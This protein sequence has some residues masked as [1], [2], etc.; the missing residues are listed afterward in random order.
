MNVNVD[1]KGSSQ[2][3]KMTETP[4]EKLVLSLALPTIVS[5]L[6]TAVYNMADT[7]FVSHLGT[8]ASAAVGIV[9]SVQSLMQS[10]GFGIGMGAGS[11]VSR[12]LG[13]KEN[14]V[15][16][17]YAM[18]SIVFGFALGIVFLLLAVFDINGLMS[19]FG[20]DADVL[21]YAREYG[22]YILMGAPV[23]CVSFVLNNILRSE[24][25]ARFAMLGLSF[26]SILN[27]LLDPVFIFDWGLG[28]GTQ[29][30][31]FATV[32]SQIISFGI[33]ISFF[34]RGKT[35]IDFNFRH[36]SRRISDYGIILVTG[37]PTIC[38]QGL[39][40]FATTLLNRQARLY[41]SAA[42][43]AVTIATKLYM[44]V[45]NIIIGLGQ[46]FQPV[47]GYNYGA[48]KIDRVKRA[49]IFSVQIGTL[50]VVIATVFF[51][52]CDKTL[53]S[54]F[55]ADDANVIAFGAR[56]LRFYC[57]S[58]PLMAYSTYANQLLQCLGKVKRATFLAA[59]RNG[60][61]FIPSLYILAAVFGLDGILLTQPVADVLTFFISIP[62][63][64]LFFRELD[65]E[66][67]MYSIE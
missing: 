22:R 26:G 3:I 53:M 32:L 16:S 13:K 9:F 43:A 51:F 24:G 50:I 57:L 41:T 23:M 12:Y 62:F 66:K 52:I 63:Q 40:A 65:R 18:S 30:A 42:V 4:V 55:R 48:K 54:W 58:L 21:P 47:A 44:F 11:L 36:V 37:A 49:F 10:A 38:R 14:A 46:G 61:M 56:A 67:E 28:L 2:Y 1:A 33:L 8:D 45:R 15:A 27:I 31:A 17:M 34:L 20:A 39:A 35:E 59:C 25:K 29:G 60:I 5:M 19:L 6:V 64:V 7:F